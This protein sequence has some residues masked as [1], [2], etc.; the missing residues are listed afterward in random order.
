[1]INSNLTCQLQK[2]CSSCVLTDKDCL[3]LSDSD[4]KL[5]ISG[6]I[7]N[8]V[9][10]DHDFD[11]DIHSDDHHESLNKCD[12]IDLLKQSG[13]LNENSS[14]ECIKDYYLYY[15]PFCPEQYDPSI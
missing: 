15:C 10:D 3:P 1:M 12:D 6:L 9:D 8:F 2:L 7:G 4:R 14:F 5:L 13:L 11:H